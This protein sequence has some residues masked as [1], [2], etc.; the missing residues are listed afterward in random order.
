[1]FEHTLFPTVLL[2]RALAVVL[3]VVLAQVALRYSICMM[4]SIVV[5]RVFYQT[6][7]EN[8]DFNAV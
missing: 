3:A 2:E 5:A 1:M 8:V 7:E 4:S 6:K